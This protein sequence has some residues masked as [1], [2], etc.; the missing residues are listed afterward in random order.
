MGLQHNSKL[1][2]VGLQLKLY[3]RMP[4]LGITVDSRSLPAI[5]SQV[6]Q[7][8]DEDSFGNTVPKLANIVSHPDDHQGRF[9]LADDPRDDTD[10]DEE[11]TIL[12]DEQDEQTAMLD[13]QMENR[14]AAYDTTKIPVLVITKDFHATVRQDMNRLDLLEECRGRIRSATATVTVDSPFL[15]HSHSGTKSGLRNAA[16]ATCGARRLAAR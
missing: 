16:A 15:T 3:V 13:H 14:Q 9:S 12:Q 10:S 4:P 11:A 1:R 6:L 8:T 2:A 5:I 7:A